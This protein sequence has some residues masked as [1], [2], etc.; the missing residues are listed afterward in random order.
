[1]K[2]RPVEQVRLASARE[3]WQDGFIGNQKA[4]ERRDYR[5]HGARVQ[6][7]RRVSADGRRQQT[8]A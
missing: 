7:R 6:T 2:L 4:F 5:N 3:E 8:S 1:V